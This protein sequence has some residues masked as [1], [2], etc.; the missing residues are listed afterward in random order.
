M[1]CARRMS[2]VWE[3][4]QHGRRKTG[5]GFRPGSMQWT[6]IEC[7]GSPLLLG[8]LSIYVAANRCNM[9]RWIDLRT[10]L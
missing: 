2:L 9:R 10:L 3:P 4:L 7:N 5:A 1:S 6:Q 8:R